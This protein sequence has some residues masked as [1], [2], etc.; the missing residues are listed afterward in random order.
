M[1]AIH[2]G[3]GNI[4]RGFIGLLLNQ[5]DYEVCFVD[6][7]ERLIEEINKVGTYQVFLANNQNESF[8]V[9]DVTGINSKLNPEKVVEEIVSADLITTAAGPTILSFIAPVI[10]EGLKARRKKQN[11]YL[12]V[13]ACEN[14]IGASSALKKF[15]LEHLNK[16]EASW[17]EE[18]VGFPD[19][20]VDRIVPNQHN[21]KL[22]DVLVE[23]FQEWVIDETAIKGAKPS[24]KEAQ[25][26]KNLQAYIER[27]L[28]TVNTGHAAT[29]YFGYV[30]NDQTIAETI[31]KKEIEAKV[32][33][34]LEETG[35]VLIK[36]H[37]FVE[38]EHF[39]Y[40]KKIIGRFANQQ[41]VDDVKRVGRSPLRKLG[42]NDRLVAP[43]LEYMQI[44]KAV[45]NSLVQV[46][47]AALTFYT[48]EDQESIEMKQL[49]EEKG[50]TKAFSE[51]TGLEE[52]HA[53]VKAV[54][55]FTVVNN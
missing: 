32:L 46:M 14:M 44:F 39:L 4:G 10:A 47:A 26:V 34:V 23:P 42:P 18:Y 51:I 16:E 21:E 7:N 1:K 33:N 28:F 38:E 37:H 54:A 15:V 50:I 40:I 29:A 55:A 52:E 8:T 5:S 2:F 13:I 11:T 43:A 41:I 31:K 24:I 12:N 9:S 48:P 45:P 30:E 20:A 49:I 3:A 35:K 19:S 27:K 25:F 36:K 6:V 53:L 17:V 22:L